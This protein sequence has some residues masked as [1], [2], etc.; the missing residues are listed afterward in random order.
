M[1]EILRSLR[2]FRVGWNYDTQIHFNTTL[3]KDILTLYLEDLPVCEW[4]VV[5][6]DQK[7]SL[8]QD[9]HSFR[10]TVPYNLR[11]KFPWL[12]RDT[13]SYFKRRF[14]GKDIPSQL[15]RPDWVPIGRDYLLY[16]SERDQFELIGL[17]QDAPEQFEYAYTNAFV[18]SHELF[19]VFRSQE[20]GKISC[21]VKPSTQGCLFWKGSRT[22]D[23]MFL[24]HLTHSRAMI[25]L[26]DRKF[27][28]LDPDFEKIYEFCTRDSRK[29]IDSIVKDIE[30][31]RKISTKFL[32]E[33]FSQVS[34][35]LPRL[36]KSRS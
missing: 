31:L 17:F 16:N 24:I 30:T 34:Y 19:A 10:R 22:R 23:D 4:R 36:N 33:R 12:V 32:A 15:M 28:E 3:T 14:G 9:H 27:K 2:P 6:T 8:I 11:I 29:I 21:E 20:N 18:H 25:N 5:S 7:N 13:A 1:K 26:I 35:P